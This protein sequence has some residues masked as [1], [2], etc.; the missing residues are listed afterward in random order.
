MAINSEHPILFSGPMVRAI[1]EGRKTQTRRVAEL[2]DNVR[3]CDGIAKGFLP[4]VPNGFVITCPYGKTG[5]RLWVRETLKRGGFLGTITYAATPHIQC[6]DPN[7]PDNL[8]G[9]SLWR[10]KGTSLPSIFMPRWASRITLEIT[11]VRVERVQEI[12]HQDALA[13][14][15]PGHDWVES[16]PYIAGPHTDA[17]ELP[18][19][20]YRHLWDSI[21]AKRGFGW[22]KNPWVWIVEFRRI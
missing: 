7:A 11:K 3:V 9:W 22:E 19:E 2:S 14:G 17:G 13:E 16:S 20:E 18:A 12:S 6:T 10:F 5:D 15:C 21:N 8:D 1:L 4:G